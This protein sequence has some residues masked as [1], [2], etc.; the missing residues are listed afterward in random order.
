M[1]STNG[2]VKKELTQ[3]RVLT[4][5]EQ[6]AREKAL[7]FYRYVGKNE[8]EAHRLTWADVRK[9]FRRL[10]DLDLITEIEEEGRLK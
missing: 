9:A 6:R 2:P 4:V 1:N 5:E 3:L 7:D 10:K 8:A